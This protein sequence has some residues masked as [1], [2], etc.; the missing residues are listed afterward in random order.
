MK[1]EHVLAI[2]GAYSFKKDTL[3]RSWLLDRSL[4]QFEDCLFF[5]P[6]QIDE[7]LGHVYGDFMSLPPVEERTNKHSILA[8]SFGATE[9]RA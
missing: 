7:S 2:G 5:C 8:L 9:S 3:K 1:T 4:K 6:A